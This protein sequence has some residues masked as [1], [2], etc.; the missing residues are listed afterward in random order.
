MAAL[1]SILAALLAFSMGLLV[2]HFV[3]YPALLWVIWRLMRRPAAPRPTG[4]A[5]V[6]LVIA[7]H[8]EAPIIVERL[9]NALAQTI[10]DFELILV[11]DG[12]SDGT[13]ANQR[14][15]GSSSRI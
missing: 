10:G 5:T 13:A 8:N 1:Q 9:K 3:L 11:S 6:S 2:F 14:V 15:R 7:A 12:S 4:T